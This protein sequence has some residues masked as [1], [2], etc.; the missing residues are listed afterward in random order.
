MIF[1]NTK[2]INLGETAVS[3]FICIAGCLFF[4]AE[5]C[6]RS[7]SVAR[8][9]LHLSARATLLLHFVLELADFGSNGRCKAV[10][11]LRQAFQSLNG[12]LLF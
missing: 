10:E 7:R 12:H 3:F 4:L 8:G 6:R 11:P 5:R 9:C 1:H 2:L